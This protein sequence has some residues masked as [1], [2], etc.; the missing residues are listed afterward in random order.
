MCTAANLLG[1]LVLFTLLCVHG[2]DVAK[3]PVII[4]DLRGFDDS[5]LFDIDWASDISVVSI[6]WFVYT[7]AVADLFRAPRI[8]CTRTNIA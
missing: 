2:Q 7:N 8:R 4:N 5:I 6:P 3:P 1:P